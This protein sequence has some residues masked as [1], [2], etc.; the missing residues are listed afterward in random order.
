MRRLLAGSLLVALAATACGKGGSNQGLARLDQT[1]FISDAA[2][3]SQ[4]AGTA[5]LAM[6]MKVQGPSAAESFEMKADGLMDFNNKLFEFRGKFPA[7]SGLSGKVDVI[8]ASGTEYALLPAPLASEMGGTAGKWIRMTK[9]Q[10]GGGPD[11]SG[12]TTFSDPSGLFDVIKSYA[13]SVRVVGVS[14]VRGVDATEYLVTLDK[15][16][17]T[18]NLSGPEKSAFE[19]MPIPQMMVFVSADHLIRRE[20]MSY[21]ADGGSFTMTF[22]LYDYGAPVHIAIPKASDVLDMKNFPSPNSS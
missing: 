14:K 21:S 2:V 4:H 13:S 7:A 12:L 17:L 1:G 10:M 5:K 16:R 9:E 22:D 6:T 15:S 19:S 3:A 20:L 8:I 11:I 18:A